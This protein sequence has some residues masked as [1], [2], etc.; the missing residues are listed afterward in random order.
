[1]RNLVIITLLQTI[2]ITGCSTTAIKDAN[3]VRQHATE[4]AQKSEQSPEAILNHTKSKLQTAMRQDL[5]FFS[6]TYIAEAQKELIAAEQAISTGASSQHVI[7][8]A[9]TAQQ[10][11]DRAAN[12]KTIAA[13]KL[14]ASLDALGVLKSINT[15]TLLP[16]DY[17]NFKDEIK[18]LMILIEQ[19]QTAKALVEEKDVLD[20]FRDLE[21]ETLNTAY[22]QPVLQALEAAEDKDAE[23]F[24]ENTMNNALQE[25]ERLEAY[26]KT[27]PKNLSE[28]NEKSHQA[29]RSAQHAKQVALAVQP[30]LRMG[31][32]KAEQHII[33]IEAFLARIG[34]VLKQE[35]VRHLSLES[36]SIAIAQAAET[37]ARRAQ[38]F[39]RQQQWEQDKL[40]LTA[41]INALQARLTEGQMKP[42]EAQPQTVDTQ[43]EERTS[44]GQ[45]QE[46]IADS[47]ASDL[48]STDDTPLVLQ[49]DEQPKTQT[50]DL[51][52]ADASVS[53]TANPTTTEPVAE[54]VAEPVTV[55]TAP[56]QATEAPLNAEEE[57]APEQPV[58]SDVTETQTVTA[59]TKPATTETITADETVTDLT[60]Q[61]Q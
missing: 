18:D 59:E 44:E 31:P 7:A 25:A 51:A 43:Q 14:S 30:I 32:E 26:I 35:D 45:T 9:L 57:N 53:R 23:G 5:E 21:I 29:I 22:L 34:K 42:L 13:Q 61:N 52:S 50:D 17:S 3:L 33:A 54:P 2:A 27:N 60:A 20:E 48:T 58:F 55:Q 8:L 56:T 40:A 41:Q 36:Q 38:A 16:D 47:A 11:L 28:I 37:T 4:Q 12:N 6:P 15:P 39:E 24:A 19:N 1:M 10:W 46:I 49:N